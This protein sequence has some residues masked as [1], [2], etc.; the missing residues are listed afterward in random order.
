MLW[1]NF[2]D[3]FVDIEVTQNKNFGEAMKKIFGELLLSMKSPTVV[4][5]IA[6]LV[7]VYLATEGNTEAARLKL[8]FGDNASIDIE[9]RERKLSFQSIIE[10]IF[11]HS[12]EAPIAQAI[13]RNQGFYKTDDDS[14]V[15]AIESL[16]YEGSVSKGIRDLQINSKGPF[17]D[18]LHKVKLSV[19]GGNTIPIGHAAVCRRS[20]FY[21][22]NL[23]IFDG[24]S[25]RSIKVEADNYFICAAPDSASKLVN[26][27]DLNNLVQLNYEDAK[28]LFGEKIP[29]RIDHGFAQIVPPDL[30]AQ[31]P[32]Q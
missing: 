20:N 4:V 3:L 9:I 7:F 23:L 13:L 26:G 31:L 17:Q 11:P 29:E 27:D 30:V 16:G 21:R 8:G 24:I 1:L 22:E 12:D 2:V 19:P 18:H 5:I 14:V 25:K 10:K 32:N 6:L 28:N 15:K